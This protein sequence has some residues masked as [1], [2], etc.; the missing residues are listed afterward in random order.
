MP[1]LLV[2]INGGEQPTHSKGGKA[3]GR[4]RCGTGPM[5]WL[6]AGPWPCRWSRTTG[7]CGLLLPLQ[8]PSELKKCRHSIHLQGLIPDADSVW[9]GQGDAGGSWPEAR[10]VSG[11]CFAPRGCSWFLLEI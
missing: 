10:V 9:K 6:E 8:F 7:L 5:Q 4:A 11:L 2:L 1:H 3:E